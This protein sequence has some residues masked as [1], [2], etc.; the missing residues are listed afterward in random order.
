MNGLA[1]WLVL[2]LTWQFPRAYTPQPASFVIGYTSPDGQTV[3]EMQTPP[4]GVGACVAVG[5]DAAPDTYCTTFP[6]CPPPGVVVFL[7]QGAWTTAPER[8]A[9][10][11]QITC[12]FT[13]A[14]P[15]VC[16]DASV[17]TPDI[18]TP[19]VMAIPPPPVF[20]PTYPPPPT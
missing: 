19:P 5:G 15:C 12:V 14:L 11:T 6:T 1:L 10:E 4:S 2:G 16:Q 3:L 9:I 18:P 7:V 17:I 20:A 8:S 13:A